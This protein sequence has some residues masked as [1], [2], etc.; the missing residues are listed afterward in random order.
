MDHFKWCDAS[1][2]RLSCE[3]NFSSWMKNISEIRKARI[4]L[5]PQRRESCTIFF[6]IHVR[7]CTFMLRCASIYRKSISCR[8]NFDLW[9]ANPVENEVFLAWSCSHLKFREKTRWRR[10]RTLILMANNPQ[11]ENVLKLVS[12]NVRSWPA[13][14]RSLES[15][16]KALKGLAGVFVLP[17]CFFSINHKFPSSIVARTASMLQF[18]PIPNRTQRNQR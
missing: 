16:Q 17:N 9:T 13:A 6:S 5:R 11:H 15:L 1:D 8:K 14:R 3:Q 7:L 2:S 10:K 18:F 12:L 4:W